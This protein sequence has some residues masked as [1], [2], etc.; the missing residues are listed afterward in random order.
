M[1]KC[2]KCGHE[3]DNRLECKRC[4]HKWFQKTPELPEV[5]PNPKCKSPYWSKDRR[6]LKTKLNKRKRR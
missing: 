3:W 4:F 1:V 6:I 5:C 2:P